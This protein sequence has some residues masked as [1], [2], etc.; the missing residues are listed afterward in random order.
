[1]QNKILFLQEKLPKAVLKAL[2]PEA[3]EATPKD[4]IENG[5][6]I[7]TEFPFKIGRESR[8]V[9]T[10][11]KLER[12]ERPNK[13]EAQPNNDLYL[14][15]SGHR[16]NI[17]REHFLIEKRDQQYFLVDRGSACGT[18]VEGENVGGD[19]AGGTVQ[20]RD[21]EVISIG[22]VGTPYIYRFITFDEYRV[23]KFDG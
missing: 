6:I 5:Y 21:S 18:K 15:D 3:V 22:A 10:D 12:A 4:L 2:T 14:V 1:M 20:L 19:D 9:N 7:I 16:L 23:I 13:G 11:G 8:V 17:S